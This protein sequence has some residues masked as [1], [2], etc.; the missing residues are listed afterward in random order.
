MNK[1]APVRVC[2][3]LMRQLTVGEQSESYAVP[4][5]LS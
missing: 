3:Y 4:Q 5:L 2:M 1:Y